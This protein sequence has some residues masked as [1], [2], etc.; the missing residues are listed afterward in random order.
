MF[1]DMGFIMTV[2]WDLL[3]F[4]YEVHGV[5]EAELASQHGVTEAMVAYARDNKRWKKK[6]IAKS[7][8]DPPRTLSVV[9]A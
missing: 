2:D 4:M 1:Q 3:E 6:A 8:R 7:A 9:K 5:S